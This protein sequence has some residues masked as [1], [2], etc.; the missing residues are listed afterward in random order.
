[1]LLFTTLAERLPE[2]FVPIRTLF[3]FAVV[4]DQKQGG[5][6]SYIGTYVPRSVPRFGPVNPAQT[7]V[8][9]Y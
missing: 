7:Q 9:P 1:M 2:T 6:M 4:T 3:S 5:E 8:C